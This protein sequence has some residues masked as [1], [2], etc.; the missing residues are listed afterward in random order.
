[1]FR[2]VDRILVQSWTLLHASCINKITASSPG[3]D[4]DSEV[5][6]RYLSPS[7]DESDKRGFRPRAY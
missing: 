4:I 2:S 6:Q 7:F 3:T 1:M 5:A